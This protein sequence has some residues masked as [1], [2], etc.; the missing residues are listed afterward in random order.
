MKQVKILTSLD[1]V[2]HMFLALGRLNSHWTG[3]AIFI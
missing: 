2:Q 3:I 1:I